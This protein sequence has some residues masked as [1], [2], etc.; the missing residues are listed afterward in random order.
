MMNIFDLFE[1]RYDQHIFKAV[2]MAGSPGS[3]KSTVAKKLFAGS[4]L[5]VVDVDKFYYMYRNQNK[6]VDYEKFHSIAGRQIKNYLDG[7][8]GML[9]DGTARDLDKTRDM[10]QKLK[11]IGY[12]TAMVFVNTDLDVAIERVLARMEQDGREVTPDVVKEVW[13]TTRSNLGSLQ[14]MFGNN[15]FIVDNTGELDISYTERQ[16]RSFLNSPVRNEIA[17]KFIN[18]ETTE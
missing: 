14:K 1:G 15:F 11:D 6:D 5:R 7:R 17:R 4:G 2:F 3:G 9:L 18:A 8:L 12:E 13:E 16:V 10:H